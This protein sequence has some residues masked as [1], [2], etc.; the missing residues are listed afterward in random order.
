MTRLVLMA[1]CVFACSL[2]EDRSAL[3]NGEGSSLRAGRGGTESDVAEPSP[4][5]DATPPAEAE[6]EQG[7]ERGEDDQVLIDDMRA[8]LGGDV[9]GKMLI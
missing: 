6:G 4:E 9:S 1:V 3:K 5:S 2:A 8:H 7:A